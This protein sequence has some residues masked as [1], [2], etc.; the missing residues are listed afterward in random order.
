M[1]VG[2]DKGIVAERID[3]I[4]DVDVRAVISS[5]GESITRDLGI[6][7]LLFFLFTADILFLTVVAGS[8]V[9]TV[10][11]S[12]MVKVACLVHPVFLSSLA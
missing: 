4:G 9:T 8:D 11:T 12:I 10:R 6:S 5:H 1:R 2:H 7:L 3:V